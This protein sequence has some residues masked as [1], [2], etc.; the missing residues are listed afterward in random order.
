MINWLSNEFGYD[1]GL[2]A[3]LR[4]RMFQIYIEMAAGNKGRRGLDMEP[5]GFSRN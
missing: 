3:M 1:T 2:T 4:L 5:Q